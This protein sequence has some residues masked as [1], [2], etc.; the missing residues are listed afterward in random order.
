MHPASSTG[1]YWSIRGTVRCIEH[2]SDINDDRWR[3]EHWLP[4]HS[5][6]Q[7]FQGV[8]YQCQQ[9]APEGGVRA[10]VAGGVKTPDAT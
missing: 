2:L 6:L 8:R 1:L 3:R 5:A 7:G 9:C 4:L 10:H